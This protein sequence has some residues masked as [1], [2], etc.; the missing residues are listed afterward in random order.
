MIVLAT[1]NLDKIREIRAVLGDLGWEL[2]AQYEFPGLPAVVEDGE[3]Y[4]ANALKKA[5][6]VAA[7]TGL[8]ALGDD[9]GLE[10]DALGGAPGM[11]SARFAG[12]NATYADN[13]RLLLERLRGVPV[14]HRG[15]RFR[16]TMALVSP[17]GLTRLVEGVIEGRIAERETG[18]GGFGYDHLFE[19]PDR[20]VTFAEL[21]PDEKNRIS[22]RGRAL[23]HIRM[24]LIAEPAVWSPQRERVGTNG[25]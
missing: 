8:P 7:Q 22:A 15:A 24:L 12:P 25:A 18:S 13:R 21:S 19:L 4:A 10:V 6:S 11:Y 23:A 1:T 3:T 9:S 5:G 17:S 16:C 20:G 14:S 2:K